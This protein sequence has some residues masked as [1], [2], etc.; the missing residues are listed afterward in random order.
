MLS[1]EESTDFGWL[2]LTREMDA[3]ALSDE[4][5][6]NPESSKSITWIVIYSGIKGEIPV[7][8]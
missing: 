8:Q 5:E 3:G 4:I 7:L 1:L 6:D 2:Y